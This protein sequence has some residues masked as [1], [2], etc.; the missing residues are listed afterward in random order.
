[1]K[2]NGKQDGFLF[3]YDAAAAT[4][5]AAKSLQSCL[6]VCNPMDGSPLL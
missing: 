5:A 2:V 4:A 3:F 1:M 6:T